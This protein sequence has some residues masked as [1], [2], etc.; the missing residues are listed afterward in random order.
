MKSELAVSMLDHDHGAIAMKKYVQFAA[1]V[2]SIGLSLSLAVLQ[3]DTFT[4]TMIISSLLMAGLFYY[5]AD[6][7]IGSG[8]YKLP[9]NLKRL[10]G[11]L[12]ILGD[13]VQILS[14][15]ETTHDGQLRTYF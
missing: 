4:T 11:R 3:F 8:S 9:Q 10:S 7:A 2:S 1:T 5:Y 13:T 14:N 6:T 15:I 12:P